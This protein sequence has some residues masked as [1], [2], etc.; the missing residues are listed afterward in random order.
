MV[1]PTNFCS[2]FPQYTDNLKNTKDGIERN[3]LN[4]EINMEIDC[5][6]MSL[7]IR[8]IPQLDCQLNRKASED[9]SMEWLSLDRRLTMAVQWVLRSILYI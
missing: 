3:E 6:I 2:F 7:H 5:D 4:I 9:F 1:C 8:G